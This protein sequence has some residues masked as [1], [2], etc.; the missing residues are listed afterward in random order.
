MEIEFEHPA[1]VSGKTAT[2]EPRHDLVRVTSN[3]EIAEYTAEEAPV[4]FHYSDHSTDRS[5]PEVI[6]TV[7]GRYYRAHPDATGRHCLATSMGIH[8][9]LVA[10]EWRDFESI[11]YTVA[12]A[13]AKIEDDGARVNFPQ[14]R[15]SK[16]DYLFGV[17]KIGKACLV[18]PELRNWKWLSSETDHE[19]SLW[20]DIVSE[21]LDNAIVVDGMLHMR[22]FEPR[23]HLGASFGKPFVEVSTGSLYQRQVHKR[24]FR[25]DGLLLM[26]ADAMDKPFSH[27]FSPTD[28]DGPGP[29]ATALEWKPSR[30]KGYIDCMGETDIDDYFHLETVRH[31][32]MLLDF[33]IKYVWYATWYTSDGKVAERAESQAV[34]DQFGVAIDRLRNALL[35]WQDDE[36]QI[37]AVSMAVEPISELILAVAPIPR[38]TQGPNPSDMQR[39]IAQ[40]RLREELADVNIDIGPGSVTPGQPPCTPW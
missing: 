4:I 36:R 39:R 24:E 11:R 38:G 27:Y 29:L 5:N 34:S 19:V 6:R 33:S 17:N 26:G 1:I 22:C 25:D 20:R 15:P 7:G 28:A 12:N 40:F 21:T 23:F 31:A 14:K 37:H 18:A 8:T 10:G 35:S 30:M 32:R 16:F 2:G 9:R 13:I 3:I